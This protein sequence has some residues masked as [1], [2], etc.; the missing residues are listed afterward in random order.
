MINVEA[1]SSFSGEID[2]RRRRRSSS[3]GNRSHGVVVVNMT[4]DVIV[5]L[6][7]CDAIVGT[8]IPVDLSRGAAT[9]VG[10]GS[11]AGSGF[12]RGCTA[13]STEVEPEAADRTSF[14]VFFSN[15]LLRLETQRILFLH[16]LKLSAKEPIRGGDFLKKVN[17]KAHRQVG[18][19]S[20]QNIT[21]NN[22]GDSP[23]TTLR[24]INVVE[25]DHLT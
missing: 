18:D 20:L 7:S 23:S 16:W 10:T 4:N 12:D 22:D 25:G 1:R 3:V 8:S 15:N 24:E 9:I 13:A 21:G 14:S 2:P 19:I 11:G 6:N 5:C 17:E